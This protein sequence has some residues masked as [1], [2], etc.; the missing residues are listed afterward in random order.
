LRVVPV[1][2][3]GNCLFRAVAHQVY[4]DEELHGM[5]RAKCVDYM[6]CAAAF[7]SQFVEGGADMFPHYLAAKRTDG[8]WGD[9]PE[10]E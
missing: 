6:E 4:G 1:S 5:V 3:D 8:C 7:F 9:D 2:G 10:I